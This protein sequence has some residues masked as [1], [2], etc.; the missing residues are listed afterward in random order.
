MED[1]RGMT[2]APQVG[3]IPEGARPSL[4]GDR[5][6]RERVAVSLQG[7]GGTV[8]ESARVV[9]D[10]NGPLGDQGPDPGQGGQTCTTHRSMRS[11]LRETWRLGERRLKESRGEGDMQKDRGR[12]IREGEEGK[13]RVEEWVKCRRT[14]R[15]RSAKV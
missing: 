5:A 15:G 2:A 1:G 6:P 7:K 13:E 12:V 4:L 10:G 11:E 3:Q 8:T 14:E 9:H